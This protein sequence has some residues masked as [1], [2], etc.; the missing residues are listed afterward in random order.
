MSELALD[1]KEA[2]K[3]SSILGPIADVKDC[4]LAL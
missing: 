2:K 1:K 4:D 3:R